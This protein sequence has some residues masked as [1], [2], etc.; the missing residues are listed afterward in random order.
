[1]NLQQNAGHLLEIFNFLPRSKQQYVVAMASHILRFAHKLT[2]LK[3]QDRVLVAVSGGMDSM[4]LL[5]LLALFREQKE[6]A[7]VR[8]IFVHH[9]TRAGQ[10]RELELVK[11]YCEQL[12]IEFIYSHIKA[13]LDA[14]SSNFE[15]K[16]RDLRYHEFYQHLKDNELLALAH[17]LDDSYEWTLLQQ[18]RSASISSSLGIPVKRGPIIRPLMCVSKKQFSR[19][20]RYLEVPFLE[21]PT[22]KHQRFERNYIREEIVSKIDKRHPMYLKHY[23]NR[24]N[25]MAK[26]LGV[27]ILRKSSRARIESLQ[28]EAMGLIYDASFTNDLEF[29]TRALK[30]MI[31]EFSNVNRGSVSSQIQKAIA[32]SN[33]GAYGPLLCSGDVNLY[34]IN[35]AILVLPKQSSQ[36]FELSDRRIEKSFSSYMNPERFDH[37]SLQEFTHEFNIKLSESTNLVYFPFWVAIKVEGREKDLVTRKDIHPL[38]PHAYKIF[39]QKDQMVF[40]SAF[41]LLYL[42]QKRKGLQTKELNLCFVH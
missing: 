8:A 33:K 28:S 6:V 17:H 42:W 13:G 38:W 32:A 12:K 3:G 4:G 25:Q 20:C 40:M 31:L 37:Y 9:G 5:C 16:A 30:E 15:R 11:S 22:N 29:A 36:L 10:D 1:M 19:F 34:M 26:S 27:H 41:R 24:Q 18:M 35:G 14:K 23:V 7:E 2:L 39:L 21:D